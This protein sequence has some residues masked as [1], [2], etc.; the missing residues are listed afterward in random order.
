MDRIKIRRDSGVPTGHESKFEAGELYFD[1]TNSDLYVF[2]G[3]QFVLFANAMQ[4]LEGVVLEERAEPGTPPANWATM[5]LRDNGSGKSQLCIK[6][7][8]GSIGV[9]DTQP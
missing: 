6:Y 1:L 7:D 2:D 8:D 3:T 4:I 9:I 5:Y